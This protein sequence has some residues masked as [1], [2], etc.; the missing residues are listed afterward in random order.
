MLAK[1]KKA[2][3][4]KAIGQTFYHLLIYAFYHLSIIFLAS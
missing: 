4:K 1:G 2:V 3:G